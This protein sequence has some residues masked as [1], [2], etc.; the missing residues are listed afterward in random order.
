MKISSEEVKSFT[1]EVKRSTSPF[2]EFQ[3]DWGESIKYRLGTCLR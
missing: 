1:V 2:L 3:W